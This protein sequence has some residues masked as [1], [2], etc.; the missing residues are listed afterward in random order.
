[1]GLAARPFFVSV[2]E[3]AEL[4]THELRTIS[5]PTDESEYWTT[6]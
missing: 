5:R 6:Q 3:I 1:M 4:R 2:F